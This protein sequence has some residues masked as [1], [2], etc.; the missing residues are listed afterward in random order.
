MENMK[1][2]Q[3]S[4]GV[5]IL[6]GLLYD[7]PGSICYAA[8]M[9]T[10]AKAAAFAPGGVSGLAIILNWIWSVP[11]G[12]MTLILNIPLVLLSYKF[13]GK[14]FLLKSGITM[15][16]STLFL[17]LIFP[18][19]PMYTGQ[20]LLA[21]I[22]SG[23]LIGGGMVLFYMHGSSSG[24]IDFLTMAI[25]AKWP[26]LSLGKITMLIDL[27]VILIGW[28]VF[29]DVDSV[30]YGLIATFVSAIVIDKVLY[31]IGAGTLAIVIT[32]KGKE[33][34][35]QISK[36]TDRGVTALEAVGTYTG[37]KK[38]VLLCACTKSEAYG[39]RQAVHQTDEKAFL[40]FTETSEV[41]G[42][43]FKEEMN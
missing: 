25:K 9:Y 1:T 37:D 26:Y 40:M 35:Q 21:A 24:G 5:D 27:V 2:K 34:A 22:Y 8:G 32:D 6:Y 38:D 4:M 15:V 42:E 36:V 23:A 33:T 12:T 43:G 39:V 30:L 13:V 18:L 3:R 29:G 20:R 7:I 11:V 41:L 10:F 16:I 19:F 17:D 28:P 14:K 31:G